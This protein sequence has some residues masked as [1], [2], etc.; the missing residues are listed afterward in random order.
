VTFCSYTIFPNRAEYANTFSMRH[1]EDNELLTDA[2]RV[3][4]LEL[5]KLDEILKKPV[6]AMTD[7][8]KWAVFRSRRMFQ[9]DM[10]SD[11]VLSGA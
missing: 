10:Q 7:L 11:M 4:Y 6:N 8:E 2:I 3:I 9:T 5:S 1:D